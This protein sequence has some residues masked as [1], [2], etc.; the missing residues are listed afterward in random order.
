MPE[1]KQDKI[2]T[3][4]PKKNNDTVSNLLL[5]MIAFIFS[6][7]L[8]STP[9]SNSSSCGTTND[10]IAQS[11][12][13]SLQSAAAIYVAQQ[14]TTPQ[15]FSNFVVSDGPATR[16]YTLSLENIDAS[17]KIF[18]DKKLT[19]TME[20]RYNDD[21]KLKAIYYLNGTEITTTLKKIK[22]IKPKINNQ[23]DKIIGFIVGILILTGF[24]FLVLR[25]CCSSILGQIIIFIL[26]FFILAVST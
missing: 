7:L 20:P 12:L 24:S 5:L 6:I 8:L 21:N 16:F 23:F 17:T 22:I 2:K 1:D 15:T 9:R 25:L 26:A 10:M 14:R 11:L 18:N 4:T 3:K 19:I 13:Q